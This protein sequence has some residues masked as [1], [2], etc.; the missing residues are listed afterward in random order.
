MM[1][2]LFY[3]LVRDQNHTRYLSMGTET[4]SFQP[5]IFY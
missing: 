1:Y 3:G 4:K 5:K 2:N